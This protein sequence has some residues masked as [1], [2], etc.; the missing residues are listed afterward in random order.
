MFQDRDVIGGGIFTLIGLGAFV[1]AQNY[2]AGSALNMGPGYLPRLVSGAIVLLGLAQI[3]GALRSKGEPDRIVDFNWRA[4]GLILAAIVTF[5]L[6]VKPA[7]LIPA[8]TLM[9]V[10]GWFADPKRKPS[11]L[12]GLLIIGNLMPILIFNL[13]LRM[14]IKLWGLF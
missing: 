12:L 14:Q 6:L 5:A 1:M 7:G 13:L 11:H 2:H 4:F 9:I 3:I 10:I 8:V